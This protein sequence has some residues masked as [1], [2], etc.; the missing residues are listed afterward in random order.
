MRLQGCRTIGVGKGQSN[1]ESRADVNHQNNQAVHVFAV[2]AAL[3]SVY[4]F[5]GM[6]F[7]TSYASCSSSGSAAQQSDSDSATRPM[8]QVA[9]FG[10]RTEIRMSEQSVWR[11]LYGASFG[12]V[13]LNA[14]KLPLL[15]PK[16]SAR[17]RGAPY[18][19]TSRKALDTL[20][21]RLLPPPQ[22]GPPGS[23][24]GAKFNRV[25]MRLLDLGSGDGRIVIAAARHGYHATGYELNPWLYAWSQLQRIRTFARSAEERRNCRF[26]LG[27]IWNVV[28]CS[29]TARQ[30]QREGTARGTTGRL[31]PEDSKNL[32]RFDVVT[33][34][35]RP[36]DQVMERVS[37]LVQN[38]LRPKYLVSNQ[39]SVP[40][41]ESKLV[42]DLDGLKLYK[43]DD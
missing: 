37:D 4:N 20:F 17:H 29:S 32:D 40:G 5:V 25:R 30:S 2:R 24:E 1:A 12:L 15:L 22:R 35:G 18:L 11:C 41:L 33:V 16:L 23:T 7:F 27:N 36:G 21:N 9:L 42:K 13:V 3:R 10:G 28:G 38:H 26:I 34:Y 6:T 19:P 14:V 31:Q 43:L 8:K 39:F